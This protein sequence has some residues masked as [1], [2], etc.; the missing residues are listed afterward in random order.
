MTNREIHV[1]FC[2]LGKSHR[3]IVN[4]LVAM[5]PEIARLEIF[6]D[7]GCASIYEYACKYAG[8]SY[9]VVQKR[10]GSRKNW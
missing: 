7:Y 8:L 5:L 6:K 3:K 2:E 4:E 1:R 10:C 9:A